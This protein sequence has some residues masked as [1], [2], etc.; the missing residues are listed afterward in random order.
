MNRIDNDVFSDHCNVALFLLS[1]AA[2]LAVLTA[3]AIVLLF[4]APALDQ[5]VI[6]AKQSIS[7]DFIM[8]MKIGDFPTKKPFPIWEL[9][10]QE[11]VA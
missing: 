11:E 5:S 9:E 8:P 10:A 2:K 4:L 3:L 7:S 6:E 1:E